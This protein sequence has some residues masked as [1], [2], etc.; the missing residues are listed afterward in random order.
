MYKPSDL[1]TFPKLEESLA[2]KHFIRALQNA[3][4]GEL[5]A[6]WAYT[7]HGE[8]FFI[9][10]KVEKA[11]VLKIREEELHHRRRIAEILKEVGAA[12][13]RSREIL[14]FC[15]GVSIGFLCMFGGWFIP[16]YGAGKLESGNIFEYEV[17][18]RLAF[19]S[20][21]E[22]YVNELLSFGELEW[23]HELY[24]RK[25][26]RGHFLYRWFPAW[27]IPEAKSKIKSSY[28]QWSQ[29]G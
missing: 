13:R 29:L 20:G 21:N 12:P 5:A 3:H 8:S 4:A 27:V 10:N 24:F 18:A 9:K 26:A 6:A 19:L 11:E 7:G 2:Q 25:K 14:M 16:M 23:D 22:K 15:I 28:Q 1:P 17:A